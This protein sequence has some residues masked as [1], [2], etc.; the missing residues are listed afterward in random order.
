VAA[1]IFFGHSN[2]DQMSIYYNQNGTAQTAANALVSAWVAASI[3]P[4]GGRNSAWR[5]C[6]VDTGDFNIYD[7]YTFTTDVDKFQKLDVTKSGPLWELEYS[8]RAAYGDAIQWP[9]DA[10]LTATF[11]H[12][13]M[14]AMKTNLSMV[15]DFNLYQFGTSAVQ[16]ACGSSKG[17]RQ[18]VCNIRSGSVALAQAY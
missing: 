15:G 11:W 4:L 13:V 6:E 5:F 1:N 18:L 8:T 7:A 3:T 17:A 2:S 10:P 12:Q 16:K 14:E 9:H